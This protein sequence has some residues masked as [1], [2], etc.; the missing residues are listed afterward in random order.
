M[1]HNRALSNKVWYYNQ[2]MHISVWK[3]IVHAV[4]IPHISATHVAI[5]REIKFNILYLCISSINCCN[6]SM[7]V[8]FVIHLSEDGHMSGRN[9]QDVCWVYNTL[10]YT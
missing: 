9:M 6:I 8:F 4:Y 3:C 5:F 1:T 10:S 2:E 7:Y